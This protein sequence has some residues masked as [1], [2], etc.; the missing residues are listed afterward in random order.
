MSDMPHGPDGGTARR[1]LTGAVSCF[2]EQGYHATS[3]REIAARAQIQPAS[4]YHW[5]SSKETMLLTVMQGFQDALTAAA[6]AAHEAHSAPLD[7]LAAMVR[8]HVTLHVQ[9]RK[10]ALISDTEIRALSPATRRQIVAG[11]DRDQR[12]FRET[13]E[14]GCARGAFRCADVSVATNAILVQCTGVASWY[15]PRGRLSLQEV[16]DVH[17]DLVC[18]SLDAEPPSKPA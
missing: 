11:R 15:R 5:F 8:A 1:I 17:A 4:V 18:R 3:M 16:A 12:L 7:R 13:I 10:E 14:D 6:V 9:H 2:F